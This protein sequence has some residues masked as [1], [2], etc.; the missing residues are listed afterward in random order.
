MTSR[1]EAVKLVLDCLSEH[2]QDMDKVTDKSG[3]AMTWLI[4]AY[5]ATGAEYYRGAFSDEDVWDLVAAEWRRHVGSNGDRWLGLLKVVNTGSP[6]EL[7][8]ALRDL[9]M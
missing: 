4:C 9:A 5:L 2:V 3:S 6:G 7:S 8:D 1:A